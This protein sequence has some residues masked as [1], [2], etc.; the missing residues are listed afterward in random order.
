[1]ELYRERD[2]GSTP[3]QQST[4]VTRRFSVSPGQILGGLVGLALVVVGVIA[5]TRTGIRSHLNEPLTDV[6]G[7]SQSA[8]I[9]LIEVGAGLLVIL[10]AASVELRAL[11][12]VV[13]VLLFA[14]GLIVAAGSASP[15]HDL[16]S[17]HGTGWFGLVMGAVAMLAAALPT[18]TRSERVTRV[19]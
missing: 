11:M 6:F 5:V 14:G 13:G 9:G 19:E 8:A 15:L 12:A 3:R 7:L 1:M 10:G 18:F 16:G 4:V 2:V 17:D